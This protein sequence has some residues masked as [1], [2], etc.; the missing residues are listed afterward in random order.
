MS[1]TELA[2]GKLATSALTPT[3][4]AEVGRM[5]PMLCVIKAFSRFPKVWHSDKFPRPLYKRSSYHTKNKQPKTK[6][7]AE[8][9]RAIRQAGYFSY[10]VNK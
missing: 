3:H 7:E 2:F 9:K 8:T 6:K 5:P 4:G 10:T 1:G